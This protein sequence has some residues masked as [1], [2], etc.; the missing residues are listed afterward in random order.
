MME[1]QMND[2]AH[3]I[4]E[5]MSCGGCVSKLTSALEAVPG[6]SEADIVLDGGKVTVTYDS[7]VLKP[8]AITDTIEDTGFDVVS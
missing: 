8:A 6:V 4:V 3:F 2:T 1:I 7:A 5:G